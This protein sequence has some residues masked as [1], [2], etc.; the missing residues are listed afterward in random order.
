MH[1]VTSSTF[2]ILWNG[3]KMPPFK[4]THGLR[5]GDPLSPYLFIICMEKLS[6]SINNAV[7]QG[8][9]EPI[10]MSATSP[11]LS[12]LLFAD[13]VL[14]F[15]KAKKSQLSPSK[16]FLIASAKLQVLR[17]IF[18]NLE[19]FT[20]QVFRIKKLTTL[21]IYLVLEHYFS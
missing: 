19:L 4:P 7:L 5:Q 11:H 18:L 20:H 10:R 2:S 12:H 17:L 6:I 16:I 15:T 8:N 1:C 13:D 21:L 14:L 3:N 9:W